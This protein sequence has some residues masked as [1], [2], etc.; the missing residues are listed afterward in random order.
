MSLAAIGFAAI[1]FALSPKPSLNKESGTQSVSAQESRPE[2]VVRVTRKFPKGSWEETYEGFNAELVARDAER[3]A[4][5]YTVLADPKAS[6]VLIGYKITPSDLVLA[7]S[8]RI[9]SSGT[10]YSTRLIDC[11]AMTFKYVGEG[12]TLSGI[13][14]SP[15]PSMST[16][17][18]GSSSEQTVRFVCSRIK[19]SKKLDSPSEQGSSGFRYV[20]NVIASPNPAIT[21]GDIIFIPRP[22][23]EKRVEY[24]SP[25]QCMD[26]LLQILG[27]GQQA[28]CAPY[29]NGEP[30][31]FREPELDFAE[32]ILNNDRRPWREYYQYYLSKGDRD[33]YLEFSKQYV[34]DLLGREWTK[35]D[36]QDLVDI[37]NA[38]A[39]QE[40]WTNQ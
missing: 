36:D 16:L 8:R 28:K 27:A 12:D 18:Y 19:Q 38:A 7:T 33:G 13:D 24:N 30:I 10:S 5:P 9:G 29:L 22:T 11:G 39:K 15:S 3:G 21:Q 26:A 17:I 2:A 1:P 34:R 20:L 37:W 31:A 4:I 23:A 35:Q 32:D 14:F 25:A 6:Y 40:S